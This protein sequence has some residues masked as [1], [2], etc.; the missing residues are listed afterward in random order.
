MI[1]KKFFFFLLPLDRSNEVTFPLRRISLALDS[2][3]VSQNRIFLSKWP[4]MMVEPALSEVTKSLQL[5]PANFVSMPFIYFPIRFVGKVQKKII[6]MII[7]VCKNRINTILLPQP[8]PLLLTCFTSKV[9]HF[10]CSIVAPRDHFGRF[11]QEF[12]RHNFTA[13]TR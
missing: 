10:K 5:E 6:T 13:M 4:L 8:L 1:I 12:C 11:T 7:K 2:D 9:P 3:L